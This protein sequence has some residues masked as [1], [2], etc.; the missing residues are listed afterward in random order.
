[1]NRASPTTTG[2][3]GKQDISS[4]EV[5]N[6]YHHLRDFTDTEATPIKLTD[7]GVLVTFSSLDQARAWAAQLVGG[8]V[9]GA[10]TL[11]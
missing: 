10:N 3:R 9:L 5:T 6:L 11:R 1:V 4:G 8:P 7:D 2:A